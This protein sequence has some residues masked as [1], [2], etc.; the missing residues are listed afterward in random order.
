MFRTLF[1]ALVLTAGIAGPVAKAQAAAGSAEAGARAIKAGRDLEATAPFSMAGRLP[2]KVTIRPG[3]RMRQA[4]LE[5]AEDAKVAIRERAGFENIDFS[6][7]QWKETQLDCPAFPQHLFVRYT[8]NNGVGDVSMFTASIPR[9]NE[10]RLRVIPIL[11][12]GYSLFSPAPINKLTIGVFNKIRA[13]EQ[14][15]GKEEWAAIGLCYAALAGARL[16]GADPKEVTTLE[17][18]RTPILGLFNGGS[19]TVTFEIGDPKPGEW[20]MEFDRKGRL[21]KGTHSKLEEERAV[22]SNAVAATA[23]PVPAN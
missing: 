9:A 18:V 5:L 16:P 19:T 7:G 10:G 4:D 2:L 14:L 21:L 12:R 6:Q 1:V 3:E 13:E 11:R 23:R 8:R 22:P 20:Q 15:E 17:P